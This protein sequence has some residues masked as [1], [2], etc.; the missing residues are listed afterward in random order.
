MKVVLN[1]A[2]LALIGAV[3]VNKKVS[4]NGVEVDFLTPEE[5]ATKNSPALNQFDEDD[6][7]TISGE[8]T[9]SKSAF[10]LDILKGL[11]QKGAASTTIDTKLALNGSYPRFDS[12]YD[13]EGHKHGSVG[14]DIPSVN[15]TKSVTKEGPFCQM[16]EWAIVN[17]KAFSEETGKQT[18]KKLGINDGPAAF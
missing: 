17:W 15:L 8:S 14:L 1:L 16:N 18:I 13:H 2:V 11:S 4:Y 5:L 7:E 9:M 10:D 6:S 12:P 3:N